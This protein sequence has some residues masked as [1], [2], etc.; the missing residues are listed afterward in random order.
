MLPLLLFTTIVLQQ[1]VWK[2]FR[3]YHKQ[4]T[5]SP[6]IS[7]ERTDILVLD[8]ELVKLFLSFWFDGELKENYKKKWFPTGNSIIQAE[9]DKIISDKFNGVFELALNEK[10]ISSDNGTRSTVALI[11]LLD[12]FS[13][14]IYRNLPSDAKERVA[15]DELALREAEKLVAKTNWDLQLSIP[16]FIF[17]LMPFRHS[18]TIPRLTRVLEQLDTREGVLAEELELL[19]K[20]KS[21]NL[22]RLEA[23]RNELNTSGVGSPSLFVMACRLCQKERQSVKKSSIPRAEDQK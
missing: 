11:I 7:T 16:E 2:R 23:Q 9:A 17:A 19:T 22:R 8:E 12:Q 14:H 18:A 15:A 4:L 13:R 1:I 21:N 20:D 5:C 3:K 6:E 10:L